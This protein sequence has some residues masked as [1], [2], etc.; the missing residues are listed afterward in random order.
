MSLEGKVALVT[1]ATSG[2]GL[3]TAEALSEKGMRLLIAG[4][5]PDRLSEIARQ[6]PHCASLVGDIADPDLPRALIEEALRVHGALD[7]C[8]NN[9]G[10]I[11]TGTVEEIDVDAVCAMVRVN[12]EAAYRLAYVALRHFKRQ[13]AGHL[14]NTSSVLGTKVR[15]TAGAYAGTKHA[16]EALSEAL[17][18]ELAGTGVKIT[19]IEPGLVMTELHRDMAVHPKE[20]LGV[21]RPLTPADIARQIV[22]VAEQPAHVAIPRL[23]ILPQDQ[24]I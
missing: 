14:I 22:Y 2:I 21:A 8:V 13:N 15:P 9:A 18:L 23:M 1:G 4:R 16:I 7:L 3:A 10:V 24:P 17:R 11:A 20:A 19:C 5:N 12:V 6:L